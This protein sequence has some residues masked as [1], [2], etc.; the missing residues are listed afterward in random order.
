MFVSSTSR[1]TG[2]QY[3]HRSPTLSAAY[4]CKLF[5][6][7]YWVTLHLWVSNLHCNLCL[8]AL[9]KGLLDYTTLI[10]A[11][12][13]AQDMFVCFPYNKINGCNKNTGVPPYM[14][15]MFVTSTYRI[16]ELD[17]PYGCRSLSEANVCKL[18]LLNNWFLL[19]LWMRHITCNLLFVRS[20]NR[21]TG[22]HFKYACTN[23]NC[24]LPF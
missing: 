17:Y 1:T 21:I 4:V 15:A 5:L 11:I 20:I 7:N 9:P 16:T 23:L 22:L 18:Y 24:S 3:N 12:S 6:Q 8:L 13:Y 19:P 14:P 10:G 2:L